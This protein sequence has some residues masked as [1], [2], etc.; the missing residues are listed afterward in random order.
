MA[1]R[2]N[3]TTSGADGGTIADPAAVDAHIA[4]TANP[5]GTEVANLGSGTL[6]ELNAAVTDANLDDSGDS[7]TPNGSATGDLTGSYPAPTL[8]TT[9]VTPGVYTNTDL[10]VTADG[11][12][13]SAASGTGGSGGDKLTEAQGISGSVPG[14][15]GVSSVFLNQIGGIATNRLPGAAASTAT[16][17]YV[18]N[19]AGNDALIYELN[20]A[21]ADLPVATYHVKTTVTSSKIIPDGIGFWTIGLIDSE[22]IIPGEPENTVTVP[23][24]RGVD[25]VYAFGFLWVIS[26]SLTWPAGVALLHKIDVTGTPAIVDTINLTGGVYPAAIIADTV[27]G[28]LWLYTEDDS[29]VTDH[30]LMRIDPNLGGSPLIDVS[31]SMFGK[32][33]Y[34]FITDGFLWVQSPTAGSDKLF[35]RNLTTGAEISDTVLAINGSSYFDDVEGTKGKLWTMDRDSD[36]VT[37]TD[38]DTLTSDG[39]Y[40]RGPNGQ[41][42]LAT[43]FGANI[44]MS[45]Y[46]VSG[47]S[48]NS[49][50]RVSPAR[51]LQ[52]KTRSFHPVWRQHGGDT[53]NGQPL[54]IIDVDGTGTQENYLPIELTITGE[55]DTGSLH[56]IIWTAGAT[57]LNG[58]EAP[59]GNTGKILHVNRT[60]AAMTVGFEAA[61]STDVNRLSGGTGTLS[62]PNL[63]TFVTI[64]VLDPAG[65]G[66]WMVTA[67][68]FGVLTSL[69]TLGSGTLAELNAAVTDANLDDSGDSRTPTAHASGHTDG[70]DDIQSATAAQKGLATATQ[71][72]KLDGIQALADV[73][74]SA[75]AIMET[76][77]D[78]KGDL[79]AATANDAVSRLAVGT[80][81]DVLTA[82]S[83]E[84]SGVKWAAG[85]GAGGA[86]GS[87]LALTA[88][89]TANYTAA[90]GEKVLW[91]PSATSLTVTAPASPGAGAAFGILNNTN[92]VVS[93][94]ISGNGNDIFDPDSGVE[95]W[96]ASYT[97]AGSGL[98]IS[99]VF[100]GSRWCIA[101]MG[102]ADPLAFTSVKTA[103]YTAAA[104]GEEVRYNAT[105]VFA[106]TTPAAPTD[107]D[108]LSF[109]NIGA[110]TAS[111]T[112]TANGGQTVADPFDAT[113]GTPVASYAVTDAYFQIE[114]RYYAASTAWLIV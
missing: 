1:T 47:D 24:V 104:V 84:V 18:Q 50:H 6:A 60:G 32:Q 83:A 82:D 34:L 90:V 109:H 46:E 45:V 111:I 28:Y 106:L 96:V 54:N 70:T 41:F 67:V 99:F 76:L 27:N 23:T 101:N 31:L 9:A 49:L 39:T 87:G 79:F 105:G 73:T 53:Y 5:H 103:N 100:D 80:D 17:L 25:G 13:T 55:C 93:W 89:K 7:R 64:Y 19:G 59:L 57:T 8:A 15:Y 29:P 52:S 112:I 75:G 12:I 38:M 107:G 95:D 4:D 91:D 21:D 86:G 71:I 26:F 30:L 58:L 98:D 22:R 14:P 88:Q 97:I 3:V 63:G 56:G 61:G 72:T 40:D 65:D 37:V 2:S 69:A 78:A 42:S 77:A 102:S 66:R 48:Q 68:N 36:L 51:V 62:V 10:T 113:P 35:K 85:G 74:A 94:T 11:R 33:G 20:G 44:W 16:Q 108:R 81:G 43:R 110:L 114:Y 92:S